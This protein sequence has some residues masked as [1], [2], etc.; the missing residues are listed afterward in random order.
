MKPQ[1]ISQPK[2]SATLPQ[3]VWATLTPSQQKTVLQILVQMCSQL[4]SQQNQE[5]KDEPVSER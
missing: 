2:P 3:Q 4:I 1:L 5:K